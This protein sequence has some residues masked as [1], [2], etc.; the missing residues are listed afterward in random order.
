[1]LNINKPKLDGLSVNSLLNIAHHLK[2]YVFR[3]LLLSFKYI[4]NKIRRGKGIGG[5]LLKNRETGNKTKA[6]MNASKVEKK[7]KKS[8]KV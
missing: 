5:F 6:Y 7:K 1:M 3:V 8:N 4:M 2:K